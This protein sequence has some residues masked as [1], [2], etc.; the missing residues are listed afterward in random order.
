MAF[1]NEN[2]GIILLGQLADLPQGRDVTIHGEGTIG[3][4]QPQTMF[5]WKEEQHPQGR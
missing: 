3:G 5:L 1:I 4:H 2:Q